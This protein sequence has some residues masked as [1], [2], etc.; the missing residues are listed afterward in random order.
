MWDYYH[1]L[2]VA[3]TATGLSN[4]ALEQSLMMIFHQDQSRPAETQ[5]WFLEQQWLLVVL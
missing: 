3:K 5:D 4:S 1:V 2:L